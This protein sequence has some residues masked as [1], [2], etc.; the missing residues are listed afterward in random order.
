MTDLAIPPVKPALL[1][2]ATALLLAPAAL[3]FRQL[4][5]V[6]ADI[7]VRHVDYADL[8]FQ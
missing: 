7:H 8:Y 6:L 1:E 3:E 5:K 2:Q 4:S